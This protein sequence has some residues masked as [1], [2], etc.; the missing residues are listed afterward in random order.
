M[1]K[2]LLCSAM[3]VGAYARDDA[4]SMLQ[5]R[6]LVDE[7]VLAKVH[8]HTS[9]PWLDPSLDLNFDN[10]ELVSNN[11]GGQ[12]PNHN[13]PQEI[14]F[15]DISL[16][17]SGTVDLVVTNTTAYETAGSSAN[18]KDAHEIFGQI[19]VKT[20]T[21][22]GLKFE[23]QDEHGKPVVMPD[24]Y[25]TWAD[26]DGWGQNGDMITHEHLVFPDIKGEP[27]ASE[28]TEVKVTNHEGSWSVS[29]TLIGRGCDNPKDPMDFTK[30]ECRG[31]EV[32][33]KRRA[34]T[35]EYAPRT[36]FSVTLKAEST[37][38]GAGRSR[39]FFF[40]GRSNLVGDCRLQIDPSDL[41][42][43]TAELVSNNLGGQGPNH[44]DPLEI[45]FKDISPVHSGT[46]DLVV[47]NTTA[48]E[49]AESS[50][51][52]KEAHEI[53]GQ[54][55]VQTNTEVGLK[56]EF[57]DEH[58]EPVVMPDFYFTWADIDGWGQ[59]GVMITHEHVVF[60]DIKGEPI[61]SE[62]TE[63][64]VTNHEGS[65]SVSSTLVG[66]GCDNPKDPMNFTRRVCRGDEVF[67]KRRAVTVEYASRTDFSVTLKAESTNDGAGRFRNFFFA[68]KSNLV[69]D[70][71]QV[72][73][74]NANNAGMTSLV[75]R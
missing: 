49:T 71:D 75:I 1:L 20:N 69:G 43:D 19:N 41:N 34:V 14:R 56:F 52:G 5:F 12:G 25:F 45:R 33:E 53:F 13:D 27:F 18:G 55:N 24:F 48:Y 59:N 16:M 42:F 46:I 51:N 58:G 73:V 26:I 37:S 39:N 28:D 44:N 30:R 31:D 7:S 65:W 60:P 4:E 72:A 64:K 10:A 29:S 63:V 23:F 36:D 47:T 22:V 40:A 62:D 6:S 50:A 66:R 8:K 3:M 54:I 9:C 17:H 38:D 61:A 11:L 2:M 32:L 68:G 74:D 15:R 57:Q 67:E 35:V 21:E 70:W